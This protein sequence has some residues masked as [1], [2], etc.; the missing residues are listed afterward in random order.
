MREHKLH[1]GEYGARVNRERSMLR[2][3]E[4]VLNTSIGGSAQQSYEGSAK[5]MLLSRASGA[6]LELI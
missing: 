1:M 6:R 4:G 3:L 5:L 2:E